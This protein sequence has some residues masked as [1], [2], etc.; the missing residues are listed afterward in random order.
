LPGLEADNAIGMGFREADIVQDRNQG[1]A[2]LAPEFVEQGHDGPGI[3]GVETGDGFVRQKDVWILHERARDGDPLG[4]AAGEGT[5]RGLEPMTKADP[6]E[7]V[8]RAADFCLR[9]PERA[10][11][12]QAAE[13]AVE[14]V[15]K[16]RSRGNEAQVLV[17]ACRP[18]GTLDTARSR[19]KLPGEDGNKARL[20]RTR[21]PDEGNM[22]ALRDIEIDP[23][24][25][26]DGPV[27][28]GIV[29]REP[30][31]ANGRGYR[32]SPVIGRPVRS[33]ALTVAATC[34]ASSTRLRPEAP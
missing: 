24:K 23:G 10:G 16:G 5:D 15:G 18:S 8:G 9:K 14:D 4:F 11:E 27:R 28:G 19:G 25:R 3:F 7:K 1:E 17:D 34:A 26:P 29:E 12:R 6:V 20:S 21:W 22:G 33:I 13:R 2:A 30:G 32:T 31:D